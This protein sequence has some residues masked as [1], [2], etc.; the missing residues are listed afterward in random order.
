MKNSVD[1][2]IR[3]GCVEAKKEL[4]DSHRGIYDS[5]NRRVTVINDLRRAAGDDSVSEI[6][7]FHPV[8]SVVNFPL[9]NDE[10]CQ[11][12]LQESQVSDDI[13]PSSL[14]AAHADDADDT[15]P[16]TSVAAG[17]HIESHVFPP[18]TTNSDPL[19]ISFNPNPADNIQTIIT[20]QSNEDLPS[21]SLSGSYPFVDI[22]CHFNGQNG[23]AE[24]PKKC[25]SPI[26][27]EFGLKNV[28]YN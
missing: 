21:A 12:F 3:N 5:Y 17:M 19:D 27:I 23:S 8:P 4:I 6:S 9:S 7:S 2:K 28:F 1:S 15:I 22:C 25:S 11:Q 16:T 26:G 14:D 10:K 13:N 20:P 18:V 24:D